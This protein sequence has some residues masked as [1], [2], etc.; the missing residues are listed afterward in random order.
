M[1]FWVLVWGL[2]LFFINYD[3]CRS[4][5]NVSVSPDTLFLTCNADLQLWG[6]WIEYSRGLYFFSWVIC[7][8]SGFYSIVFM[9]SIKLG[10][11]TNILSVM[12]MINSPTRC[13]IGLFYSNSPA[14]WIYL[15]IFPRLNIS[16]E[17]PHILDLLIYSATKDESSL[18]IWVQSS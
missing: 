1:Y 17:N 3:D 16:E 5:D 8:R 2:S 18:I 9:T 12:L 10:L 13:L 7:L 15:N 4:A 6:I 11:F 14:F